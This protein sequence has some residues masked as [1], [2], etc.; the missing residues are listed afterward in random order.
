MEAIGL[1]GREIRELATSLQIRPTKTLGQNFVID[2]NTCRKIVRLG[3]VS[4]QDHV[5]EVG[6]GLGS[7]TIALL[8][9]QAEV[10]AIEIDPVLA[11]ALPNTMKKYL[12]Q[13]RLKV[14]ERDALKIKPEEVVAPTALV[15]NLPYNVSVPVLLHLLETFPTISKGVVMVQSEVA[16]RLVAKPGTAAYG[17]PTV[18][19]AYWVQATRVGNVSPQVF[20]PIPRVDSGLVSFIRTRQSKVDRKLLFSIIDAAF[21]QRRKTLRSGLAGIAGS[22]AIAEQWLE[23]CGLSIR[24]RGEELALEDFEALVRA[25]PQ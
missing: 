15:A 12:P 23:G 5:I 10:T 18:K 20:W 16:D 2:P 9:T 8:N 22:P 21:A 11:A 4:S 13:S 7:L 25:F 24:T 6:P 3:N 1:G 19:F 17:I 14:L